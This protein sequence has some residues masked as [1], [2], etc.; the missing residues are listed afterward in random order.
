MSNKE[1]ITLIDEV[2]NDI[3][4]VLRGYKPGESCKE[5]WRLEQINIEAYKIMQ[6]VKKMNNETNEMCDKFENENLFLK[7]ENEELQQI[8][9]NQNKETYI[10]EE[11]K[12]NCLSEIDIIKK[13][14]KEWEQ[15]YNSLKEKNNNLE[16]SI[17]YNEK[18]HEDKL[19][20]IIKEK[21][22][23]EEKYKDSLYELNDL[24]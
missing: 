8:I 24:K 10:L 23:K 14:C 7:K 13:E 9:N 6:D 5:F 17:Y 20:D 4:A 2:I 16:Q 1:L 12:E 19:Q 15:K 3:K 21:L 18:I 22:S 11:T